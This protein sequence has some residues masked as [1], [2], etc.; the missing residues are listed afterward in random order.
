MLGD[1]AY[2]RSRHTFMIFGEI[3]V[4]S[5]IISVTHVN[6]ICPLSS[7][8]VCFAHSLNTN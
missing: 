6:G 5:P 7:D 8:G 3:S 1:S 4:N 2:V